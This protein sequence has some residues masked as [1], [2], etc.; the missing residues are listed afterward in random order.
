MN[1]IARTTRANTIAAASATPVLAVTPSFRG[2]TLQERLSRLYQIA[3]RSDYVF[4]SPLGP[5]FRLGRHYPLPRFVYFGPH[6]SD[7]S[8]RLAFYAGQDHTDLRATT[9]LLHFI[10]RLATTPD[11]GHGLNL[12]FFPLIDVAGFLLGD[13]RNLANASWTW[14]ADDQEEIALLARDVRL[15]AYH[16]FVRLESTA[17]DEITVRLR[18]ADGGAGYTGVELLN[19]ADFGDWPVRWEGEP[20][21]SAVHGPLTLAGDLPHAPFE[22]TL[23]IPAAWGDVE[24]RQATTEVLRNIIHRHRAFEANAWHI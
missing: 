10:E 2:G 4:A 12:G 9:A 15:S 7:S 1:A 17:A 22:L 3:Q 24:Y 11:L 5:F 20:L 21:S 8:L 13:N 18:G 23:A 6:T 16:G 19:S 14:P